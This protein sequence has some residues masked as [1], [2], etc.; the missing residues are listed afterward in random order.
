MS[1]AETYVSTVVCCVVLTSH[2]SHCTYHI[3]IAVFMPCFMSAQPAGMQIY[4]CTSFLYTLGQGAV[5][6][7]NACRHFVGLPK[8]GGPPVEGET[9]PRN[10]CNSRQLE[11]K[12]QELRGNG[13]LLGRG[14]LAAGLECSFAGTNRP[15]TIIG[16]NPEGGPDPILVEM[17][18]EYTARMMVERMFMREWNKKMSMRIC[19]M[20]HLFREFRHRTE[21]MMERR[22]AAH[23]SR[24]RTSQE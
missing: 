13:P 1:V 17:L 12:A 15:S 21:E 16:S 10:L 7:N 9:W 11:R 22:R 4:L 20:D 18:E 8:L 14:V 6:R 19:T 23:A 2:T 5:L 3:A 24:R